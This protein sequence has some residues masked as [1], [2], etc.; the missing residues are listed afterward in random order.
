MSRR[1]RELIDKYHL[2]PEE[3][4]EWSKIKKYTPPGGGKKQYPPAL[5][6]ILR[7]RST[8]WSAFRAKSVSFGWSEQTAKRKWR[9]KII[10]F[11]VQP[12]T[13]L[14]KGSSHSKAIP[15]IKNWVAR[16][17]IRGNRVKP[18][19]SVWEYYDAAYQRVPERDKWDTPRSHRTQVAG[20]DIKI[21]EL[22]RQRWLAE[23]RE[24]AKREPRRRDQFAEQ[25]R[26]LGGRL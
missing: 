4:A 13:T 23:L 8:M 1:Y 18:I 16:R 19:L 10:D 2:L 21:K 20:P 14:R 17:D 25:A 7:S 3:A 26:R 15:R 12:H 24:A 11:Y 22:E 6:R 5:A 9:A